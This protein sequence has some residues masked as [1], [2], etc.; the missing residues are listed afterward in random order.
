[1]VRME[2]TLTS[3]KK[4]ATG[5]INTPSNISNFTH[6]VTGLAFKPR[7]VTVTCPKY[8]GYMIKV[9]DFK[10]T[11]SWDHREYDET[12]IGNSKIS[13]YLT[14]NSDGFSFNSFY[15]FETYA[16]NTLNWVAYE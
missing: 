4:T 9:D 14:I 5:T 12:I 13:N 7:V 6:T 15:L 8:Y 3:G 16:V 11:I 2:G 10:Y 1:M